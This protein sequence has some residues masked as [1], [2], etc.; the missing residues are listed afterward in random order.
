MNKAITEG[1]ALMPPAFNDGLTVWSS[2]DGRPGDPTYDGDPRATQITSDT[3]F[4]QCLELEKLDVTQKL[5]FTGQ[6]PILPGCYL[7]I[8]ARVKV[9]GGARPSV[10]IGA[11]AAGGSGV[12]IT[13]LDVTGDAVFLENY[14]Q[15]YEVSALVGTGNR[16]GVD[17]VWGMTPAYGHFG[18]D[19]IGDTGGFVRIESIRIED[20]TNIFHRDLMDWIDVRDYGA[21]GDGVT[22]DTD[23]LA[24]ADNAAVSSGKR[25]LVS[26]G[27]YLV[28]STL[29]IDAEV[30]FQGRISTASTG[31]IALTNNYCFAAYKDAFE[32]EQIALERALEALYNFTDHDSL[33]LNGRRIKLT[34][35]ID[36]AA[37]V[38]NRTHFAN[39]RVIR[40]GQIEAANSSDFNSGVV[41][42][43]ATFN[44]ANPT[45][46][47]GIANIAAIEVGSHVSG[48]G[49]GREVYVISKDEAAGTVTLGQPLFGAQPSQSYTFT[50]FRYL[51][52]FSGFETMSRQVLSEIEFLCVHNASAVMLGYNGIAWHIHDCWFVRPKDRGITSF[53][54]GCNGIT[55]ETNEFLSTD[56]L[57]NVG[58][59]TSIAFNTN[60]NDMKVRNNRAVQF[61]HF[62]VMAGGG[63]IITGNHWWQGDAVVLNAER[64]AGIVL[65]QP[66]TKTTLTGNYCDNAWIELS[67]EHDATPDVGLPFGA[68]SIVGN[69]F[70]ASDIAPG[71]TYIRLVPHG[72]ILTM[73]GISVVGNSFKTIGNDTILR[74]DSIDTT[75]GTINHAAARDV[76]FIGNT[77]ESVAIR[78]ESPGRVRFFQNSPSSTWT[79]YSGARLPF[80]GP[81]QSAE[82][83]MMMEPV[84]NAAGNIVYAQPYITVNQEGGAAVT[85][86]WPEPVTGY[87]TMRLRSDQPI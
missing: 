61:K 10:R 39:R 53:N 26:E 9:T 37:V 5:R 35:P 75:Y 25:L 65:T 36:V 67:N 15:V 81:V 77:Y 1:L 55:I 17:L 12:E 66:N 38:K 80:D 71:F 3:N 45:R 74:V 27:T 76:M 69:I 30:R 59:R 46:L 56:F 82:G 79:I 52:D 58:D 62:A 83:L 63:H 42:T 32:D 18:V 29:T 78:T 86:H 16:A 20:A 41:T 13:G 50:R 40:N 68:V 23:A 54:R 64:S 85:L 4:G 49:V 57:S 8:S 2:G 72:S 19:L 48:A 33:D 7:K 24:A 60:S 43:T 21:L 14:N 84:R 44:D 51:L 34:R 73:D 47:S 87:I 11:F 6:T 22:D 70:T 31:L 28:N